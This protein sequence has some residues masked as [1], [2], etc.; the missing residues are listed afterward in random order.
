M[1]G[2]QNY[3]KVKKVLLFFLTYLFSQAS[4]A[5][6]IKISKIIDLEDPW[7]STFIN[8]KELIITEKIGKIK[9]IN[10]ETGNISEIKHNINFL[11]DG[12]GGLLDIIYKDQY[13]WVSYSEDRGSGKSNTSIVK[14]KFNNKNINFKNIFQASPDIDSGYHYG[15]R[16]AIKGNQI[17]ASI[18]ERG[19]GMIAQDPTNHTGSI[20]RIN[21]DGTIPKDNPN[22]LTIDRELFLNSVRRV[23]IFSNKTT[24][25]IRIKLAGSLLNISAEDFDFSNRADENLE[26]EYSGDDIQ[27]GFNSKFLIEMLNNLDSETITLSM[28]HPNRAGIIR[29][30]NEKDSSKES[31]TMLVMPVMLND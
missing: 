30:V 14:G 19:A 6:D 21:L 3:L 8:D 9:L 5:N 22:V 28:S 31:I 23:S 10:I 18:G 11:V 26:C 15:S 20:I 13:V 4:F 25:Q 12:Q 24:N 1:V 7:G 27:I 29:P 16:L 2:D 17:Y